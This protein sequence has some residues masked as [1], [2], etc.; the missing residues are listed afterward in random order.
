MRY[1]GAM[2]SGWIL[3][4]T[5]FL[6]SAVECVEAAT[7]VLA[8]G[9][10]QGWR[11][12]LLGATAASAALAG[13]VVACGPLL[14]NA[15]ALAKIQLVVAPF[16]ILFGFTWLRKAVLRFAGRLRLR[17]EQAVFDREVSR[18]RA[19]RERRLG[20][21]VAFQGV[22]VEG[23]EV[24]VIV[25]TFGAASMRALVW[26]TAGAAIAL[27]TVAAAA[28]TFHKPF[29]RVPENAMKA[30]VGVM[31][32]SLGTFWL[33]EALGFAWWVGDGALFIIAGAY[34]IASAA[35]VL[36][37]RRLGPAGERAR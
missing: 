32:V 13:V 7:I 35:T 15:A 10:A 6:A 11:G 36:A 30:V 34:A 23:L 14:V 2:T 16:L 4:G 3:A 1:H 19:N 12:A 17:D 8:V 9:Y 28:L 33:G 22:F 24:A 29:A 20:F 27:L 5:T 21:A 37:L 26:S 25:V 18:L 31:L